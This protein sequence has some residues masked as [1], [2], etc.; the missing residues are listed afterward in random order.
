MASR[1]KPTPSDPADSAAALPYRPCVGLLIFNPQRQVFIGQRAD[2]QSDAWQ[3]PQ[4]GIDQGET[5]QQAAMRELLEEVGTD[6]A[7]I[8]AELG[9]WLTYDL[10]RELRARLWNGR[11]RGQAQKWFALRYL[12]EDSDINIATETP[13]FRAWRWNALDELIELAVPFKRDVYARVIGEFAPLLARLRDG[14]DLS[15]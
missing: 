11:Y 3:M 14:S 1:Q 4:G 8:V 9:S 7:R 2:A 12:G 5:P 15:D 13:E 10:P 6:K